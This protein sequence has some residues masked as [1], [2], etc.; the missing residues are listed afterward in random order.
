MEIEFP[1]EILDGI[2]EPSRTVRL[3]PE[4]GELWEFN[5]LC[6]RPIS[7]SE[8]VEY[9]RTPG[10]GNIIYRTPLFPWNNPQGIFYRWAVISPVRDE[11]FTVVTADLLFDRN[12][13]KVETQKFRSDVLPELIQRLDNAGYQLDIG[14]TYFVLK[15]RKI[16]LELDPLLAHRQISD[17]IISRYRY[18]INIFKT[19][20]S[21]I[22]P[23]LIG[24]LNRIIIS[25]VYPKNTEPISSIGFRIFIIFEL[26]SDKREKFDYLIKNFSEILSYFTREL[27]PDPNRTD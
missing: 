18:L 3:T 2:P 8:I 14:T 24:E 1:A 20:P 10:S 25:L 5:E 21:I 27:L 13:T 17:I 12:K 4:F 15:R 22:L 16:C 9:S 26:P 19:Y 7:N 11:V 23:S 6:F